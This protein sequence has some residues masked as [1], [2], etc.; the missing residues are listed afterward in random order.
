[1]QAIQ[2]Q[3]IENQEIISL[4]SIDERINQ[5]LSMK[6]NT[7][8]DF[9]FVGDVYAHARDA[10]K[11]VESYYKEQKE[12]LKKQINRLTFEEKKAIEPCTRLIGLCNSMINQY[13]REVELQKEAQRKR[14][15]EDAKIL[16]IPIE[17][18]YV[19]PVAPKLYASNATTATRKETKYDVVN[20]A[21]VPAEY[22]TLNDAAVK[23]AIKMGIRKI[24][25]LDIYDEIKRN[26][27]TR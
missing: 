9:E 14:E 1:M 12:P 24:P 21:E 22:L 23:R 6:I 15:I 27:K 2:T 17:K 5:I 26:L 3:T 13:Y 18:V 16:D 4:G 11:K 10:Q 20:I 7:R 8:E 25:G 19:E